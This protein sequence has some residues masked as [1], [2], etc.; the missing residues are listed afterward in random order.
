MSNEDFTADSSPAETGGGSMDIN[1][2][3]PGSG[4]VT[5][6]SSRSWFG[7]ILDSLK[8]IL[9]G[10]VLVIVAGVLMFWNE[11][12]SAK[13]A[14]ALA[15]GAGLVVSVDAAKVDPAREGQLVHVAGD[16]KAASPVKDP[17]FGFD[18]VGLKL[19][20]K[21]EMY[22][23]KEEKHS[24][25]QKKL[26]GGEETVTRYTYNREWSD[27][28]IDSSQ[29]RNSAE[30][31]NP[32]MPNIASRSFQAPD[33]KLGAYALGEPV[34]RLLGAQDAFSAPESATAQA[35]ARLGQRAR[36]LQGVVYSGANPDQPATGD[37]RVAWQL[38]PLIPV[39]VVA[40]QT[41]SGFAPW[42]AKNGNEILLAET[43]VKEAALLFKHGQEENRVLTWILRFVGVIFMF[44]GFR[45]MLSLLEALADVI[46][47]L[48]NVVGAGASL[49]ALLFTAILA[50][51]IIAVAWIFYRPLVAIGALV[52]GGAIVYGL[53]T[54]ARG[55]AAARVPAPAAPGS[56]LHG[57]SPLARK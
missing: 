9:I 3:L 15:E 30:H 22:Q 18:A 37:V 5:E 46:P 2:G 23:W 26:G 24:E 20:R 42:T 47:F 51:L 45:L 11:G 13:T 12:R 28:A 39:S 43:G 1:E 17:D 4:D 48:G 49:V 54:L 16:T 31:R 36:V 19:T 40:R 57:G 21:V 56:F 25:T 52:V 10:L 8:A 41:Q 14:A 44:V 29:F 6:T 53:R 33:A 50:P 55:R 35:R 32:P 38:L 27:K 7:K 34:V